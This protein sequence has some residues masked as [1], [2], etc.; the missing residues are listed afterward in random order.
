[1]TFCLIGF[2]GYICI[3]KLINVNMQIVN[4]YISIIHIVNYFE[5][6]ESKTEKYFSANYDIFDSVS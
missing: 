4:K 1:M 3:D 2:Y 5:L 6:D